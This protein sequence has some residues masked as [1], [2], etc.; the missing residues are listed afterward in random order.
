[1]IDLEEYISSI[2][3]KFDY[4][5]KISQSSFDDF[6]YQCNVEM[7]MRQNNKEKFETF[8]MNHCKIFTFEFTNNGKT[9]F[10]CFKITN[11]YLCNMLSDFSNIIN[12][13]FIQPNS[14]KQTVLY[15]YSS[16]NLAKD[17]HVGHLRSTVIGDCLANI[18]ELVGDN[19]LRINHLGDFGLPFGIIV[20]Y[21]IKHN[22]QITESTSLQEIYTLSKKEFEIDEQFKQNAYLRTSELQLQN[23]DTVVQ[24][25]KQIY[26]HSLKS[27][28]AIYKLLNVS[29]MQILGESYYVKYINQVKEIL[30]EKGCLKL[31]DDGRLIV[32]LENGTNNMTYI[33]SGEKGC[34]YTYDTTDIVALWYRVNE[35]SADKIYYVVDQGQSL[36]FK[37]LINLANFMKWN[38]HVEHLSFGVITGMQGTR[39]ASRDGNTPKLLDLVNDGIAL[40]TQKFIEK[41]GITV[42]TDKDQINT[43]VKDQ[44]NTITNVA[45]GSIKYYELS[46]CRT[47]S[48]QFNFDEMLRY[49]S[50]SFTYITYFLA[51]CNGVINN[52]I[53]KIGYH[54]RKVNYNELT[55]NDIKLLKKISYFSSIISRV[56]NTQMPHYICDYANKLVAM[57]HEHYNTTRCLEFNEDNKVIKFN[58][59]RVVIYVMIKQ[60]LELIFK[61]LGCP[62]VGKL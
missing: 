8:L 55:V 51:R 25:W 9:T 58:E 42:L 15:D 46:K 21:I 50:N 43:I 4:K 19:V 14:T 12:F 57:S 33:K 35:V 48:Y 11:E 7:I 18:S 32:D 26:D 62:I 60:I 45:I 10:A 31:A 54:P 23:N 17:M 1:M 16:P 59:T 37:Q 34:A 20:E 41:N 27:Y 47:T 40:T 53:D 30:L 49:D 36:H 2:V 61:L 29:E 38:K 5:L 39:I 22:I 13:E 44:I 3:T 56:Y 24:I 28:S 52:F 6:D